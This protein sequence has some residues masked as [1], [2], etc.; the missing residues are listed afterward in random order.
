MSSRKKV[1]LARPSVF[2]VNEMKPF[3]EMADFEPRPLK[4][5]ATLPNLPGN[6]IAGTVISTAINS[7]VKESL[8][9][10]TL[11]VREHFPKMPLVFATLVEFEHLKKSLELKFADFPVDFEFLS[12]QMAKI[13]PLLYPEKQVIVLHKD[14]IDSDSKRREA[15]QTIRRFFI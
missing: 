15:A 1:L 11:K 3:I 2:I 4:D 7:D 9:D 5:L 6:E 13:R 8:L 14:D 12:L 10:V